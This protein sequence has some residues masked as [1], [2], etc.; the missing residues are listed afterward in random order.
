MRTATEESARIST[1]KIETAKIAT[2]TTGMVT[3]GDGDELDDSDE[4]DPPGI[5]A[6]RLGN[7]PLGA[8]FRSRGGP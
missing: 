4:P 2:A 6:K 3:T 8:A 5:R 1:A 7:R